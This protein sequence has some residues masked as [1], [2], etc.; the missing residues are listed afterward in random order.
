MKCFF[1]CYYV[2]KR[3]ASLTIKNCWADSFDLLRS[4]YIP[5]IPHCKYCDF[6]GSPWTHS[7]HDVAW[8]CPRAHY[9][10][11]KAQQKQWA[12]IVS[13]LHSEDRLCL[14]H[15][16]KTTY[17][18]GISNKLFAAASKY[19]ISSYTFTGISKKNFS[20]QVYFLLRKEKTL[21]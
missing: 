5:L 17:M 6:I 18:T 13:T 12:P 19:Q 16:L 1:L 15:A 21:L 8:L 10:C 2:I 7:M 9:I 4:Y 20:Q 11:S 3:C 14:E